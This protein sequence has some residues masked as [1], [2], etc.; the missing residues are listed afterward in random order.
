MRLL[1]LLLLIPL[2]AAQQTAVVPEP[3]EAPPCDDVPEPVLFADLD[4]AVENLAFDGQGN[5]FLTAFAD[6]LFR[7]WPDG[8]VAHVAKD[9][10]PAQASGQNSFMGVDVGPDGALYVSEGVSIG[11]PVA[12]RVLRFPVPGEPAFEVYAEGMD[13]ANGLAVTPDGVV[14]VVHGFRD[15]VWRIPEEGRVELWTRVPGANGLV[16]HPDGERLVTVPLADASNTVTAIPLADPER[17]EA[18]FSF[19]VGTSPLAP[20]APGLARPVMTKGVDDLVVAEDG[21]IYAAA[22]LRL[23][24]LRGDPSSGQMCIL[25]D[26]RQRSAEGGEPTSVRIARGFGPWDG[27]LFST[28]NFGEVWAVDIR[29]AGRE[30]VDGREGARAQEG[31]ATPLGLL[32]P[33]ALLAAAV[34]GA[35]RAS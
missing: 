35:R 13:G 26:F 18:L 15:E 3:Q 12:A 22:H 21:R 10:R 31:R 34:Y 28:D 8:T 19:N 11:T 20:G 6:G 2:A 17:R 4:T 1:A 16:A 7:A 14:F 24:V 25:L 5:L 23:Q 32:A 33:V 30:G 29:D 9:D 27:W